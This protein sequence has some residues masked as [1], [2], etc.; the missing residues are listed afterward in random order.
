MVGSLKSALSIFY[1]SSDINLTKNWLQAE[2]NCP[3]QSNLLL[4]ERVLRA[5]W[6]LSL[7]SFPGS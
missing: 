2:A 3:E 6:T 1:L 7:T 5:D 4:D